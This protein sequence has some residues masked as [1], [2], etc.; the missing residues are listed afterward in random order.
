M[1]PEGLSIRNYELAR[2]R[3]YDETEER[4]RRR[5]AVLGPTASANLFGNADPLGLHFRAGRVLFEVIGVT[6]AKGVDANGA[7]QDDVI[8]VPL[9]TAMRRLFNVEYVDVLYVQCPSADSLDRAESEIRAVLRERHRLR[10]K[11]DDFTIQNQATLVETERETARSLTL[12]VG[13]VAAISLLV[14]GIGILA[15]MLITV[16]ER[17]REIGLR[18]SLGARR[19]DIRNQFLLE[20]G[21][22]SGV[23]ALVGVVLGLIGAALSE[24]LGGWP[25]VI[26]WPMTLGAF[27]VSA[28][29]GTLFGL[30]PAMRA[31]K[32]EPTE[33]LRAS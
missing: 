22:L 19:R 10:D 4:G 15:V 32:M 29:L 21:M 2:G 3:F 26:S 27:V 23:G 31:A 8:F 20:S 6:Q 17:T 25:A 12:L 13:S 30:Y 9:G 11:P 33:A 16:R 28:G 14:G 24:P 7:D 1:T 18:R 5:V